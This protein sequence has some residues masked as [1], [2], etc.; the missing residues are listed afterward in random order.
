L[1]S[2]FPYSQRSPLLN[3]HNAIALAFATLAAAIALKLPT[4]RAI[5]LLKQ[6]LEQDDRFSA[7]GKATALA[8]TTLASATVGLFLM[9]YLAS[10]VWTVQNVWTGA[11]DACFF[12]VGNEFCTC[13]GRI[14]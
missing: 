2:A 1:F 9:A 5:I 10:M 14:L 12:P 8:L 13:F 6:N 3:A 7:A 11:D 4:N